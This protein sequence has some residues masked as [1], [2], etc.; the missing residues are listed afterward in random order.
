MSE[1]FRLYGEE[2]SELPEIGEATYDQRYITINIDSVAYIKDKYIA[3]S[4]NYEETSY[5]G[6]INAADIWSKYVNY[7]IKI[8]KSCLYLIYYLI[9]YQIKMSL[10]N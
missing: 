5:G 7:D 6:S 8:V 9:M 2:I 10:M 4:I 1:Y 3:F